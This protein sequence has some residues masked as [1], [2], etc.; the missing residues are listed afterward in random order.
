MDPLLT[1]HALKAMQSVQGGVRCSFNDA[2]LKKTTKTELFRHG[3]QMTNWRP[4]LA[5][6]FQQKLIKF[7]QLYEPGFRGVTEKRNVLI[8]LQG[9]LK[10]FDA[11]SSPLHE[12]R[13]C[14]TPIHSPSSRLPT[15]RARC[16]LHEN[17]IWHLMQI[18]SRSI[19]QLGLTSNDSRL[20]KGA[21]RMSKEYLYVWRAHM[22]YRCR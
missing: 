16:F 9:L 8:F 10:S 20:N 21:L 5:P 2:W 22:L 13:T 18:V 19:I 7:R 6:Q 11:N 1:S 14:Y 15:Q 12:S 17:L 3:C 4:Y